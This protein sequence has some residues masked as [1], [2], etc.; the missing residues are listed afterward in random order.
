MPNNIYIG[1]RYVPLFDGDW[2]NTKSYEPLTIVSY[3]NNTYTSKKPVPAGTLPTD[4]N[5]WFLSGNYNGQINYLQQ[6][7]DS[8]DDQLDVLNTQLGNDSIV[9][10]IGDSYLGGT[11]PEYSEVSSWGAFLRILLQNGNNT[12]IAGCGSTGFVGHLADYTFLRQLQSLESNLTSEEKLKVSD[13]IVQGGINDLEFVS[14]LQTAITDFC[15]YAGTHFPNAV[16]RIGM[17]SWATYYLD[18]SQYMAVFNR[19]KNVFNPECKVQFMDGLQYIMPCVKTNEFRDN[20]IHPDSN[21]SYAIA[22][23]I[24][25]CMLGGFGDAGE[26]YGKESVPLTL[27][28]GITASAQ[29]MRYNINSGDA[30]IYD[31]FFW[32]DFSPSKQFGFN[33]P[34]DIATIG[35]TCPIRA[36]KT[37]HDIPCYILGTDD[38]DNVGYYSGYIRLANNKVQLIV[39]ASA[40]GFTFR[41]VIV[42]ASS[43]SASMLYI[44]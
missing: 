19:Y 35:D 16:V 23:G 8:I 32:L 28:S 29:N 6:Q 27:E 22:R 26:S 43:Y 15:Q 24:F 17:V 5:Y 25:N 44:G 34:V 20:G 10:C 31:I 37:T 39:N 40:A 2:N 7:I 38:N 42:R 1:S 21:A 4:T 3:G 33:T 41:S 9:L 12:K 30:N 13:I 14:T 18:L 11:G 36:T